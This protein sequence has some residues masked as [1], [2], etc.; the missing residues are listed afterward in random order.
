M[1]SHKK[2]QECHPDGKPTTPVIMLPDTSYNGVK[3]IH[4]RELLFNSSWCKQRNQCENG[5]KLSE[6]IEPR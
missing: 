3:I 2:K 4:T 1:N 6:I 5:E